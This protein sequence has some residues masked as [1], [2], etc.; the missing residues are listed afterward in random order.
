M[1]FVLLIPAIF[2][3]SV[4]YS[5]SPV[6]LWKY[7]SGGAIYS[8]AAVGG[9]NIYFG[10]DDTHVYALNK[11][12]GKIVW[13]FKTNGAIKSTPAI[14]ENKVIVASADGSIYAVEKDK[15]NV[16]W[17]FQTRGEQR[18]DLWDYYLSSPVV[19][20]HIVYVGSGDS[21]VYALQAASGK[22]IWNF[23]TNGTVHATP[24]VKNDTVFIGSYDGYFYALAARSGKLFWKFKTVGD[25]NFP[26]GEIQ[27]A[28][29]LYGNTVAFGSRDYNIYA[30]DTRTGTGKWNMKEIGS[31]VI[32]T[33]FFYRDHLYFGTSD[34][35]R[36]YCMN[37][38]SGEVKWKL[39]LNM[40]VYGSAVLANENIVFGS[41][42]GKL[43]LVNPETGKINATFQTEE[44]AKRYSTVYG[45][46]NEFRKGFELYGQDY[47]TS[48]KQIL[49]LGSILSDP[50]VDGNTVYFGDTNG[51]FYAIKIN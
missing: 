48:E 26:K 29:L 21:S 15:G 4:V 47:I 20:G 38:Y 12:T 46:N 32:A 5:Q 8:S 24:V 51:F 49:S 16:L 6:V 28:A 45:D 3:T 9:N 10:S 17:K 11:N 22:M 33:P 27:R 50:V 23:K 42:N 30:L 1:R 36:F 14:E 7:P 34:T 13:K 37:A 35:H 44:S 2:F 18:Y 40:R 41:F 19:D 43:Y 31:W 25:V 39:P